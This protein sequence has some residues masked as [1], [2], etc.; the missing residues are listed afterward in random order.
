MTNQG[1]AISLIIFICKP[2]HP[3]GFCSFIYPCFNEWLSDFSDV[4]GSAEWAAQIHYPSTNAGLSLFMQ[5]FISALFFY[6]ISQQHPL[7]LSMSKRVHIIWHKSR[8]MG[9]LWRNGANFTNFAMCRDLSFL[10]TFINKKNFVLLIAMHKCSRT[11]Q[12]ALLYL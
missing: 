3:N 10:T 5:P 8:Q 12:H 6:C 2:N 11:L 4:L 1:E 7:P 9:T